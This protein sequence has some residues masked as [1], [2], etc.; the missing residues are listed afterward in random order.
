[1]IIVVVFFTNKSFRCS[2]NWCVTI[3]YKCKAIKT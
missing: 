3:Y 2:S 1:M